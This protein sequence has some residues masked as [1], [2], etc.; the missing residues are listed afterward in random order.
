MSALGIEGPGT[1]ISFAGSDIGEVVDIQMPDDEQKE[2]QNTKLA[3]VRE[4]FKISNMAVG[5][6]LVLTIELNPEAE[7]LAKKDQGEFIVTLPIQTAGNTTNATR[8]FDGYVRMIGGINPTAQGT[9]SLK[10][11]VTIRLNS[12]IVKVAES[13]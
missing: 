11:D 13:A 3:S 7:P 1:L 12:E 8:T 6:V 2:F 5:Q 4:S 10:Q 9:E